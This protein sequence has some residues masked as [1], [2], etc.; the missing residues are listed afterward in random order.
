MI[1]RLEDR[2][3]LLLDLAYVAAGRL[4]GFWANGLGVWDVAAGM[5]IA[6]EAGALTSDFQNSDYTSDHYLCATP[7][8]FKPMLEAIKPNFSELSMSSN[9]APSGSGIAKSS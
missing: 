2:D 4:D 3:A 7:K 1:L 6:E 5:L 8:C 9:S